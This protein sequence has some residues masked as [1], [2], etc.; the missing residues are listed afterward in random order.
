M[1]TYESARSPSRTIN[2]VFLLFALAG[3]LLVVRYYLHPSPSGN[4]L[5]LAVG[6]STAG[7]MGQ[8]CALAM[9]ILTLSDLDKA[10]RTAFWAATVCF[11]CTTVVVTLESTL[12]RPVVPIVSTSIVERPPPLML[13]PPAATIDGSWTKSPPKATE[14]TMS[15][16][17]ICRA[18]G[19][20]EDTITNIRK[21]RTDLPPKYFDVKWS[22]VASL[23][24][25]R[26]QVL[27]KVLVRWPDAERD[28]ILQFEDT[29]VRVVGYIET[30]RP[31]AGNSESTN[32]NATAAAD[33]D[34]H[35]AFVREAGDPEQTS[36]V[37]E[38]TPRVRIAHP[39]WTRKNLKPWMDSAL[40]VRFSGWLLFDPE[41]K[42]HLG[43]FRQ[44]LWEIHPI[45]KIEVSTDGE[46]VDLDVLTMV[47]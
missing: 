4:E 7:L 23:S 32:C 3:V 37:S 44:T 14:F 6:F 46:W 40:P 13:L 20:G 28:K 9:G 43:R 17:R 39:A 47:H 22:A 25:P 41:H 42:N 35:I 30:I 1:F 33:T 10:E 26:Q 11:L 2:L 31:Q 29:P 15:D 24:F 36:I 45:T 16:G 38:V 27:P 34:W 18:E 8:I 19:D 12:R 21:N 5:L